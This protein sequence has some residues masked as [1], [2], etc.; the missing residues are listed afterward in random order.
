MHRTHL[1]NLSKMGFIIVYC[2]TEF[3]GQGIK[4]GFHVCR[5][6]AQLQ[7]GHSGRDP[8]LPAPLPSTSDARE[9]GWDLRHS[10]L[11]KAS[12]LAQGGILQADLISLACFL[13]GETL[14]SCGALTAGE[15]RWKEVGGSVR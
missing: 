4:L 3:G 15:P 14:V 10:P 2:L 7:Q 8:L 9:W 1:A 12:A 5:R 13:L 6:N 11:S